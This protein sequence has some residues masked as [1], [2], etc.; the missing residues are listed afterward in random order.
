MKTQ[1]S[2]PSL[3]TNFRVPQIDINNNNNNMFHEWSISC[4]A[5]DE[6][7]VFDSYEFCSFPRLII[8]SYANTLKC[9]SLALKSVRTDS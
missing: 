3:L 6:R 8:V 5:I 9:Q 2:Q 1:P 7:Q 4:I